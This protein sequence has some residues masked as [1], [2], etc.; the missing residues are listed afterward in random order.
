[1]VSEAISSCELLSESLWA[2]DF[3][4]RNALTIACENGDS[5]IAELLLKSKANVHC[6]DALKAACQSS[7]GEFVNPCLFVLL[8]YGI[9]L[10]ISPRDFKTS[11]ALGFVLDR[12]RNPLNYMLT[13]AVLLEHGAD[14]NLETL[15]GPLPLH[16]AINENLPLAVI[17]LLLDHGAD[18]S[19]REGEMSALHKCFSGN[20]LHLDKAELLLQHG[21]DV[22]QLTGA[23]PCLSLL[24]AMSS[25]PS[26]LSALKLLI[27]YGANVNAIDDTGRTPLHEAAST[28]NIAAIRV[29]LEHGAD[30][31]ACSHYDGLPVDELMSFQS[32]Q[33]TRLFDLCM[34][35]MLT[36]GS[37][38]PEKRFY[39]PPVKMEALERKHA[40]LVS[41]RLLAFAMGT[42]GRLGVSSSVSLLNQDVLFMIASFVKHSQ[43]RC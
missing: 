42:H 31:H 34:D 11:S 3:Y 12:E 24:H 29:L 27:K 37:D 13:L 30:V 10:D 33:N 40:K 18:V 17:K 41:E 20:R 2:T 39:I 21:A 26:K 8:K 6:Y 32:Q 19:V 38:L 23:Y 1:M 43:S 25:N 7:S 9:Y 14:P 4:G 16:L 36:N 5:D 22:N 15:H 35:A 28:L